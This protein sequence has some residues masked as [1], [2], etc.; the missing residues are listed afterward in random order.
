MDEGPN[1]P[2]HTLKMS[3]G[4]ADGVICPHCKSFQYYYCLNCP[5]NKVAYCAAHNTQAKNK[6]PL[7]VKVF[8]GT[9]QKCVKCN[10]NYCIKP[11]TVEQVQE[12]EKK[13]AALFHGR[14]EMER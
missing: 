11:A 10:N 13:Q 4:V 8:E 1:S 7:H 5:G 9:S 3:T 12:H 14:L 6:H 2:F